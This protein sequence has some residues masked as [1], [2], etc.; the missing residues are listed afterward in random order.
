MQED[1]DIYIMLRLTLEEM[2]VLKTRILELARMLS[3]CEHPKSSSNSSTPSS[4][5]SVSH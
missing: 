2:G 3:C 1:S 4:P 5:D